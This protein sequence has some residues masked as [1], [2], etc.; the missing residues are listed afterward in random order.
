LADKLSAA[1]YFYAHV[2]LQKEVFMEILVPISA[3]VFSLSIPII[4]IIVDYF[5]KKNKMRVIEKAIEKGLSLEGLSFPEEKK[6][7]RLPYRG[8][9]VILAVGLGVGIFAVL[10][11]RLEH[12]ALY[13]I[14]GIGSI[15]A[16]LGIALIINDKM[17]Y[18]RYFKKES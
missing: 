9:M 1:T 14:L 18:D 2:K 7:P 12:E 3:I 10:V 17:N 16:L 15:L 13:P 6:G 4:V 8:G 11:G 5:N